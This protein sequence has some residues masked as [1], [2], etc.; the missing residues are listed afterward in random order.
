LVDIPAMF[1]Q[2]LGNPD[3]DWGY[4]TTPQVSR[5]TRIA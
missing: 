3:Y 1:L 2:M 4:K 5:S